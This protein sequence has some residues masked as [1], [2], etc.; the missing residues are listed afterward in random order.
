MFVVPAM[1]RR[2][3][4]RAMLAQAEAL[5]RGWGIP[6]LTLRTSQLPPRRAG[7]LSR[8]R[9]RGGESRLI[10]LEGV[11]VRTFRLEKRLDPAG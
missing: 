8:H 11:V 3:L 6:R 2:G 5:C 1:R 9:L 10:N 4:G 7:T